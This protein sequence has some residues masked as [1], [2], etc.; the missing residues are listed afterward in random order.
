MSV[1]GESI[2]ARLSDELFDDDDADV[3]VPTGVE[4]GRTFVERVVVVGGG[5]TGCLSAVQLARAGYHVTLVESRSL[6]MDGA[7]KVPARLH[8]GGEYPLDKTLQTG[9]NCLHAALVFRQIMPEWVFTKMPPCTFIV[10]QGTE[11]EGELTVQSYVDYY[12]AIRDEYAR[13]CEQN[14]A[15]MLFGPP[16]EFFRVLEADEIRHL[17]CVAGGVTTK[18]LG[19]NPVRV[20]A[21]IEMRL[22][23]LGVRVI[24]NAK[25]TRVIRRSVRPEGLA[26]RADG[27]SFSQTATFQIVLSSFTD[28]NTA[29][30]VVLDAD[31]ILN[32]SWDGALHLEHSALTNCTDAAWQES[33][34]ARQA[35]SDSGVAR[36]DCHLRA[37]ALLDISRVPRPI[38]APV[39]MMKGEYGGMWNPF[40]DKYAYLYLPSRRSAYIDSASLSKPAVSEAS[41]GLGGGGETAASGNKR[42]NGTPT[43]VPDTWHDV[44]R[45]GPADKQE[46][47]DAQ[48]RDQ[49]ALYPFLKDAV[50]VDL[51]VRT[52]VNQNHNFVFKAVV[53]KAQQ[54]ADKH[55]TMALSK[56]TGLSDDTKT[57]IKRSST[58]METNK[59][60]VSARLAFSRRKESITARTRANTGVT[61]LGPG[62]FTATP[63]KG[64]YAPLI[65]LQV[66]NAIQNQSCAWDNIRSA[67]CLVATSNIAVPVNPKFALYDNGAPDDDGSP[68]AAPFAQWRRGPAYVHNEDEFVAKARAYA[69]ARGW[70]EDMALR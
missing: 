15:N 6:L 33:G 48:M 55:W 44:M 52:I 17:G 8:L 3:F 49:I 36:L 40:N 11:D 46:R 68:S 37:M 58:D 41:G 53:A 18:E 34:L 54:V 24:T 10:A 14:P 2:D 30:D 57:A 59:W 32:S 19:M 50:A 39:F 66:L 60:R 35:A 61:T 63:G 16:N 43:E 65:S 25:V 27:Q 70:P 9:K 13:Y 38:P 69:A 20:G 29:S 26:E 56:A 23:Q 22:E 5:W 1:G 4:A 45:A 21:A 7:S 67:E 28:D 47:L 42:D 62:F 12:S 51:V 64:T 31:Q